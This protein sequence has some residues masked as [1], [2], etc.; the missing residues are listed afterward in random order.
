MLYFTQLRLDLLAG[1]ERGVSGLRLSDAR[2]RKRIDIGE[3][4]ANHVC[5]RE[6]GILTIETIRRIVAR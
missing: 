4:S 1:Q 2:M 5:Y 3:H 6:G